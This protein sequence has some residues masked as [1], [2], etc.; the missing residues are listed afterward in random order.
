M[1]P[2]AHDIPE[3]KNELTQE[4]VFVCDNKW[5]FDLVFFVGVTNHLNYRNTNLQGKNKLFP[6]LV[7]DI[8][9]LK[10]KL[11]CSSCSYKND[12]MIQFPYL[13]VADWMCCW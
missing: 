2:A 6:N 1:K 13:K 7:N 8:I 12:D 5:V 3:E 11:N 10:M 4:K 9:G